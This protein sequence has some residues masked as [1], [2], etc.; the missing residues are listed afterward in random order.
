M[1]LWPHYSSQE[2]WPQR[3]DLGDS[4]SLAA[5]SITIVGGTFPYLL[6]LLLSL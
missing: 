6:S 5:S 4:H 3:E 2:K 1:P